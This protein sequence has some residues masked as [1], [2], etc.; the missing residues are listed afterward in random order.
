[1]IVADG[2]IRLADLSADPHS[3]GPPC[4]TTWGWSRRCDASSATTSSAMGSRSS[5]GWWGS[6]TTLGCRPS[7]RPWSTGWFRRL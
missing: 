2:P 3:V 5:S 7:S 4:S 1:V 6:M